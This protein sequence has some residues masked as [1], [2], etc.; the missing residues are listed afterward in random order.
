MPTRQELAITEK[1]SAGLSTVLII[2]AVAMVGGFL[3][4]LYRSSQALED[5]VTP[6]MTEEGEGP[7][8]ITLLILSQ[9]PQAAVGKTVDIGATQVARSLGRGVFLLRLT[10]LEADEEGAEYPVL[11]SPD[12]IARG[13]EVYGGEVARVYGRIYSLNDSIRGQWVAAGAVEE[14]SAANIPAVTSFLLAD[15]VAVLR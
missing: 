9:D 3:L 1:G 11:L 7:A 4:W 15:S 10:P 2:I 14:G 13:T 8:A 12:L 5:E 6:V